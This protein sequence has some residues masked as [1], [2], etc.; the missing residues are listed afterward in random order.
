MDK[1]KEMSNNEPRITHLLKPTE[2]AEIL[3]INR[4][5]IYQ[6]LQLGLIP[7]V[8]IGKYRRIRL[9]DLIKFIESNTYTV[10]Q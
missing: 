10:N 1:T 4:S 6:M 9:E 3:G 2:A 7:N 5:H 8:V